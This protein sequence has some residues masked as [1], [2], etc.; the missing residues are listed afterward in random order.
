MDEITGDTLRSEVDVKYQ[1]LRCTIK[2]LEPYSDEY[3]QVAMEI[4]KDKDSAGSGVQIREVKNIFAIRR[5]VERQDFVDKG[6]QRL[7]F[8]GSRISNM[9]GIL[10]RG[11]LLPHYVTS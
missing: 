2:A 10:S 8:H 4:F 11:L 1:G 6:N 7:L 5:E 3:Q 9:L